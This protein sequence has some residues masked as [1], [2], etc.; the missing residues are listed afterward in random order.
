MLLAHHRGLIEIWKHLLDKTAD[1]AK[2]KQTIADLLHNQISEKMRQQKR[3]KEANF[4]RVSLTLTQW[5]SCLD[6]NY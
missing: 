3:V 1:L 6:H 5:I 4:K 2:Q